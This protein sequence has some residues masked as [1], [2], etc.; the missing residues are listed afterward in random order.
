MI[1]ANYI[2]FIVFPFYTIGRFQNS[3][4]SGSNSLAGTCVLAGEC[5][6]AGG[7]ATGS[8]STLTRQAVCC[9][10]KS[11]LQKLQSTNAILRNVIILTF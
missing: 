8:C 11:H 5:S 10:C 7:I 3:V 4:C 1:N 6:D 9:V 2:F